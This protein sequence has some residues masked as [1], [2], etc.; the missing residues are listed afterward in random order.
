MHFAQGVL[1][2]VAAVL[3]P[4]RKLR[5]L[6]HEGTPA[7]T[8]VALDAVVD[9]YL[10]TL[11]DVLAREQEPEPQT[12]L[13]AGNELR[14]RNSTQYERG[15]WFSR[16]NSGTCKPHFNENRELIHFWGRKTILSA[17]SGAQGRNT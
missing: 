16:L 9:D 3:R 13:G 6:L 7:Q 17:N 12:V 2:L 15:V 1:Q 11:A 10:L 4:G 8:P 5:M 14:N